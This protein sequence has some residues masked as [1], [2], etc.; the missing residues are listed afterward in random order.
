M[1]Q[2]SVGLSNGVKRRIIL[3]KKKHLF[4][5]GKTLKR[6]R[7]ELGKSQEDIAYDSDMNR[8]HISDLE[9][10][11]SHPHLD[12]TIKLARGL[13]INYCELLMEIDKDVNFNRILDKEIHSEE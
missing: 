8:G 6:L 5:I 13:G 10:D 7:A 12:T 2:Y 9:N 4:Y 11:K 1:A 3:A